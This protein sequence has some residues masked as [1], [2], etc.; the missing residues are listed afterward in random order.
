MLCAGFKAGHECWNFAA[1][2]AARAVRPTEV[3]IIKMLL[4]TD[5]WFGFISM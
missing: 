2:G 1:N 4:K 3:P 5:R